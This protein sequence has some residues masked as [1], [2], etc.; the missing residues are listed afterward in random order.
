MILLTSRQSASKSRSMS[1]MMR[2]PNVASGMLHAPCYLTISHAGLTLFAGQAASV[3]SG[4]QQQPLGSRS[5][6]C[7]EDLCVQCSFYMIPKKLQSKDLAILYTGLHLHQF[8]GQCPCIFFHSGLTDCE[9]GWLSKDS[10]SLT[11]YLQASTGSKVLKY[12]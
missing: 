12:I 10:F 6:G 8:C 11:N 7:Q 1:S 3:Q 9:V 2:S 4:G 5:Q